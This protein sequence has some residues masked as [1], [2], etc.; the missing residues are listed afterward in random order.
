MT[1]T[2]KQHQLSEELTGK[3]VRTATALRSARPD[4]CQKNRYLYWL[5]IVSK[6]ARQLDGTNDVFDYYDFFSQCG[7]TASEIIKGAYRE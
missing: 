4:V 7:T 5:R 3:T 2:T 6:T 1:M